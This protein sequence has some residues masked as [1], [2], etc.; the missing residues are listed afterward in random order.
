MSKS[1]R[2]MRQFLR[3]YASVSGA[4]VGL[5]LAAFPSWSYVFYVLLRLGVCAVS[6]YWA[7]EMLKQKQTMWAW[8][9]GA[10]AV[11]FNLSYRYTWR[12]QIGRSRTC[13][14]AWRIPIYR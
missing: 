6:I 12:F 7:V 8:A 3:R 9:L 1:I 14:K 10:N 13:L 5:L 2:M 11:L 4:I